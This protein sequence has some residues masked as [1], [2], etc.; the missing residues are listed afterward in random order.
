MPNY[1]SYFNI[2]KRFNPQIDKAQIES[3]PDLWKEFYP[4]ESFVSLIKTTIDILNRTKR[5]SVWVEGAYG[6]GKSHAVLTLKKLLEASPQDAEEYFVKPENAD[7]LGRDL[8]NQFDAAK[9]SGKIL[10]VHR[11][12]SSSIKNDDQLVLAMQ[13]SIT[14]A[15]QNAGLI[16]P[17]RSMKSKMIDWLSNSNNAQWMNNNLKTEWRTM[18]DG[19]DVN[20]LLDD[21]KTFS[22]DSLQLLMSRLMKLPIPAFRLSIEDLLNWIRDIIRD[23]DLKTFLFIWDEFTEYF[24]N[25]RL[26]ITGFQ[27]IAEL[28]ASDN[29]Y[30][31]IVTHKSGELFKEGDDSKK[32][33]DR[34]INPTCHI[35]LPEHMAF[36]LIARALKKNPSMER[37]WNAL[38]D[39]LYTHTRNSRKL[40]M[41]RAHVDDADLKA[42][43]PLH[44]YTAIT[45]K[46]ISTNYQS[47]QRSMFS[48][49]K[50]DSGDNAQAFQ[51]F[52]KTHGPNDGLFLVD[53]LWNFFYEHG[54]QNLNQQTRA[55]LSYYDQTHISEPASQ[56][57]L[58]AVLLLQAIA[59]GT[60]NADIFM[61]TLDNIRM[62]FDGC[63]ELPPDRAQEILND[64]TKTQILIKK[65]SKNN[66]NKALD[67]YNARQTALS[68][69]DMD[70][71]REELRQ[72]T[73]TETLLPDISQYALKHELRNRFKITCVTK[74]NFIRKLDQLNAEKA[75]FSNTIDL[76]IA[77]SKTDEEMLS[78][79][80]AI[81]DEVARLGGKLNVVI[82]LSAKPFGA[83]RLDQYIDAIINE[84]A[85]RGK[86][87]LSA[88][89]FHQDQDACKSNWYAEILSGEFNV[90]SKEDT[91]SKRAESFSDMTNI[92]KDI[93]RRRYSLAPELYFNVTE[94]LW[95]DTNIKLSA[96]CGINRQLTGLVDNKNP[97]LNLKEQLID[98]WSD[99]EYWKHS[100]SSDACQMVA[101]LKKAA[102]D[103]INQKFT[104]NGKVS[105]EEIYSVLER[106]PYGLQKC[107]LTS[108]LFGFILKDYVGTEF[109]W[110]NGSTSDK[111]DETK[112]AISIETF[113][114]NRGN[115][116]SKAEYIVK[117]KEEIRLFCEATTRVFDLSYATCNNIDNARTSIREKM[118]TLYCPIWT[119]KYSLHALSDSNDMSLSD[120]DRKALIEL[121]DNYTRFANNNNTKDTDNDL[122][123]KIGL[124]FKSDRQSI[125]NLRSRISQK[126]ILKKALQA[127]IAQYENGE[128]CKIA[129]RIGD[130]QANYIELIR[131]KI[132]SNDANWLWYPETLD[133]CIQDNIYEYQVIELSRPFVPQNTSFEETMN[134]WRNMLKNL[135]IPY[136]AI[137]NMLPQNT[138][139]LIDLVITTKER[140][141]N[142]DELQK[143][144]TLLKSSEDELRD[145]FSPARQFDFFCKIN[146]M[147][148]FDLSDIEMH[149][150]FDGTPSNQFYEAAD[151]YRSNIQKRVEEHKNKSAAG[152]LAALWKDKTQTASPREWSQKFKM[153]LLAMLDDNIR[154]TAERHFNTINTKST[155]SRAVREATEFIQ[156]AT[157]FKDIADPDKRDQ[158][159][160]DKILGKPRV[161]LKDLD[162]V[163]Q[164]LANTTEPSRWDSDPR[165][166]KK[167]DELAHAEYKTTGSA[168]AI[169]RID[170]LSPEDLKKYLK[171]LITDN[172][173]VGIEI[174]SQK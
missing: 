59:S 134:H 92:L 88:E 136:S 112:L 31:M 111:L 97:K 129:D 91:S 75:S 150:I 9:R 109:A 139:A 154:E 161:L 50:D 96:I 155:E 89:K 156:N 104:A 73:T 101:D 34:F 5:L 141:W 8:Y 30:M 60:N 36:K 71:K 53:M 140:R 12:G 127:Y 66:Q 137:Q 69:D 124:Q 27:N 171:Q 166:Q 23:N 18:F 47:N 145:F 117:D 173:T 115:I 95:K 22:G 77:H 162:Y 64:L 158:V 4:H 100:Q 58:K 21:L 25:N 165:V 10:V 79:H 174:L 81:R 17:G 107:N 49:I 55:V 78:L 128:L 167:I 121:I 37:D 39:D 126:D 102:D 163:R 114:R 143:F 120:S 142:N 148:R 125:E 113:F 151:I 14:D 144:I 103:Q 57:V 6:T 153:P 152:K 38:V 70:K 76:L 24:Q 48:F 16:N 63:D 35:E 168:R 110:S 80:Q 90:F 159:F 43:L 67:V 85:H 87:R 11:Y 105:F 132:R 82:A 62:V 68:N 160:V 51:W 28:S 56:R 41:D 3:Q 54:K 33:L 119:L 19:R 123:T 52:I 149:K 122:A 2:D 93:V 20:T 86:D 45:L 44:P 138:R 84:E 26:S 98:I 15:L 157:F 99:S 131:N 13:E 170:T 1:E 172:M 32:I 46:H 130:R 7:L 108:F 65:K 133:K 74:D 40:I 94:A 29:F 72:K 83:D 106:A 116:K 118:K 61:P 42:I 169:E 147:E 146:Q 164:E 135:Q